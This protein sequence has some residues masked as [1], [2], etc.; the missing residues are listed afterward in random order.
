MRIAA[1]QNAEATLPEK[2]EYVPKWN[3]NKNQTARKASWP[4]NAACKEIHSEQRAWRRGKGECVCNRRSLI[5][6]WIAQVGGSRRWLLSR[7]RRTR[8]TSRIYHICGVPTM[9]SSASAH[10]SCSHEERDAAHM[11][12]RYFW[13]RIWIE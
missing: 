3:C 4:E 7:R 13:W 5:W 1:I 9:K 6:Q 12:F 10:R 8:P 11:A 2:M